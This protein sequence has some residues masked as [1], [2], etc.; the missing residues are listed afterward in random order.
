MRKEAS[1]EIPKNGHT[2]TSGNIGSRRGWKRRAKKDGSCE[3]KTTEIEG[4]YGNSISKPG[5]A[6][7]ES[8][9]FQ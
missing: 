1:G 3:G 7:P 6:S 5:R 2:S 9:K 8:R 4:A